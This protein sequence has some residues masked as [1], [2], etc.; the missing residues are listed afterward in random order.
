MS[1]KLITLIT[2]ANQGIGYHAA[3]KLAATG[4]HTVL[5]GCRDLTKGQKAVEDLTTN[6]DDI[7][8]SDIEALQI[9]LDSDDSIKAAV[10]TVEKKYGRLDIVS[11]FP[12][13]FTPFLT[14]RQLIN[15]AGINGSH[16]ADAT[17][18]EQFQGVFNTN[19]FGAAVV[20]ETFLPLLRK[21]TAEGG[22]RLVFVSS[23]MGA[24]TL[25]ADPNVYTGPTLLVYP[26]VSPPHLPACA[27][28]SADKVVLCV[29]RAKQQITH[30]RS[31]TATRSAG[32]G[33][34]LRRFVRV[35]AIRF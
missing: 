17:L 9:D 28:H 2:G 5:L 22:R 14:Y 26:S 18:R 4:Q 20:T 12:N 6:D 1:A 10:E 32:R 7:N 13:T 35:I 25:V 11:P 33:L 19:V 23:S 21:S 31:T 30:S 29:S 16:L 34:R 27:G 15:N 24:L 3:Q 8:T